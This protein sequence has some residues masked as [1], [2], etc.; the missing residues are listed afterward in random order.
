MKIEIPEVEIIY[1]NEDT[2]KNRTLS[3]ANDSEDLQIAFL[4]TSDDNSGAMIL[5]KSQVILLR[6]TLNM[7]I[8]NKLIE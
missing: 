4:S 1:P 8:K 6:D 3:I 5:N 2:A 7:F